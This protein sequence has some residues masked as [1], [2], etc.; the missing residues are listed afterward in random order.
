M[1]EDMVNPNID[2][3][4]MMTYLSQYP[5]AKLKPGAP[6]KSK[7]DPSKV[8]VYGPGVKKDG[9]DTTMPSADFTV[10]ARDAGVG[11]VSAACT[12][13]NGPVKVD[14]KDNGDGTY[15]CSYV[16]RV[17]GPYTV[18]VG[19]NGQ[20]VKD[21]PFHVNVASGS[22]PGKVKVTGPG[23]DGCK[24]GE[25]LVLDIDTRG[26]GDGNLAISLGG[27]VEAPVN[28]DDH[29]DGTATMEITPPEAGEYKLDIKF[30][31]QEVPGAPFALQVYDP[32][33]VKAYGSGVTG[34]GARVGAPAEVFVDT[35]D[36]GLAPMD[37]QVT[38]PDGETSAVELK[39]TEEKGVFLGSYT[40]KEAGH[41]GLEVKFGG[42]QIPD[43]PFSVP[44]CDPSKV[45][46]GG[47]GLERAFKDD[48]NVIDVFTEGAGPGEVG[49]E[50]QGPQGSQPVDCSVQPVSDNHYQVHYSPHDIGPYK[51]TVLYGGFPVEPKEKVVPCVDPSQVTVDG[52]HSGVMVGEPAQFTVDTTK[53]GPDGDVTVAIK[54]AEGEEVP[55]TVSQDAPGKYTVAYTPTKSGQQEIDVKFC[56]KEVEGSPFFQDVNNP[57]AVRAYGPG[58][59]KAIAQEPAEFT[60]D[61]SKA[62]E[63]AL[64]LEIEGPADCDIDCKDNKDGTFSVSYVAPRPG[65]Y[66]V[67]L[68]FADKDVPGS[69][70]EVKCERHPPD[71]S[72]CVVAF[73]DDNQGLT[74]DAK[75]A[76]GTGKLEVCVCGQYVPARFVSVQHNGDYTFSVS[77]DIPEPGETEVSV[78]WH[79]QHLNGSP[80]VVVTK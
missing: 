21:S 46:L 49:V 50:F 76:G 23:L 18:K 33:K 52:L 29:H 74:V 1:P 32:T 75:N 41:H 37:V 34:D 6:I 16:P 40:P 73:N 77:Y 55:V 64:S 69:P 45:Q 36:T 31:G 59:E 62:G 51:V 22:D 65:I 30:G 78:K 61:A 27:P 2:E 10:D 38:S 14:V 44:I 42:D 48:D 58:L 63:G 68:K 71:A 70:F 28:I 54:S 47:P 13:P 25:K 9:L 80:F 4:S 5:D 67:I 24:V 19:F 53:A 43:S 60:V 35:R 72:K 12:G 3:L 8:K 17:K 20:P 7:G 79:G 56:D 15:S 39:P 66:K 57:G 11:A 26:A